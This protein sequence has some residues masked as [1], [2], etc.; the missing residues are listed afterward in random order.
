MKCVF[1]PVETASFDDLIAV[2]KYKDSLKEDLEK[3]DLLIS[4]TGAGSC[5]ETGKKKATCGYK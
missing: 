3:A 5:L 1:V 2:C 4:H